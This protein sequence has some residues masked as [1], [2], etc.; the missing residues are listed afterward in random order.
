MEKNETVINRSNIVKA[1]KKVLLPEAGDTFNVCVSEDVAYKSYSVY[2][3]E[4]DKEYG[5]FKEEFLSD[6]FKLKEVE[7]TLCE[8]LY[9]NGKI[10]GF[11]GRRCGPRKNMALGEF[12][13]YEME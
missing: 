10:F 11:V 2:V 9:I 7:G 12:F 8:P 13:L 3:Q 6:F 5:S 1:P 4:Q